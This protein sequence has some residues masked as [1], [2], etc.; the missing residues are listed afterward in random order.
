MGAV[1]TTPTLECALVLAR[2]K[3]QAAEEGNV[4]FVHPGAEGYVIA[5]DQPYGIAPWYQVWPGGRIEPHPKPRRN[6]LDDMEE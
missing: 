1:D 4:V 2:A 6:P 3:R 5:I